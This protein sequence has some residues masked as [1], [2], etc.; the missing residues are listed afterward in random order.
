MPKKKKVDWKDYRPP[1]KPE[2][3]WHLESGSHYY[4]SGKIEAVVHGY[5]GYTPETLFVS[6]HPEIGIGMRRL[7]FTNANLESAKVEALQ[8]VGVYLEGLLM[9]WR[10]G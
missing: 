2:R 1:P 3:V 6:T 9:G 4:K 8:I 5:I 10:N 7:S